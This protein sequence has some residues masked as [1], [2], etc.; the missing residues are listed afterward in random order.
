MDATPQNPR[1]HREGS[2]LAHT[3][4]VVT[5]F[6]AHRHQFELT[7]EETQILYWVAVLHDIGK[8]VTTIQENGR[9]RSPGH[10]RASLAFAQEILLQLD[11]IGSD[12]RRRILDLVRWHGLPLRFANASAPIDVVKQLGTRT[13]LRLLGIFVWCD[14]MGRDCDDK[15]RVMAI[16]NEFKDK[17][18]PRAEFE[19]GRYADLQA[20]AA[21]WNL[22]HHNAVWNAYKFS[23]TKLMEK[24]VHA[25]QTTD[26]ETRGQRVTIVFGPPS[27]GKSAWITQNHPERFRVS[28]HD[29]EFTSSMQGNEY[30]IARKLIELKHL[31]R[32]YLNR[33]QHVILESRDLP[34][35]IRL[36][37]AESMR[38][39]PVR[40]D[41]V[42]ME[43]TLAEMQARNLRSELPMTDAALEAAYHAMDVY[44]PWE[45][46]HMEYVRSAV[47]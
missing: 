14:F 36:R 45:A 8:V 33:H 44:H 42:I 17:I 39:M 32:V 34:E 13:D 1:Y 22:R 37:L 18:A 23:D 26:L 2:V 19:F 9:H 38:D 4:Y 28:L 40:L 5:Q 43:T 10:E 12:T 16:M 20:A 21:S 41:Y 25:P 6:L 31:M 30:L 29:H 24:L 46:H 35:N 47:D 7:E 3:Q 11:E 15:P 27:A